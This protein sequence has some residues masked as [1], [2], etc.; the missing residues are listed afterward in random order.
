MATPSCRRRMAWWNSRTCP[1]SSSS[2]SAA[3]IN[4]GDGG[5]AL[6]G[7]AAL[8]AEAAAEE[9][10]AHATIAGPA[11]LPP[12]ESRITDTRRMGVEC[13]DDDAGGC[14]CCCCCCCCGRFATLALRDEPL[15]PPARGGVR[16]CSSPRRTASSCPWTLAAADADE[17][18]W[19][20]PCPC[21]VFFMLLSEG[22]IRRGLS[23]LFRITSTTAQTLTRWSSSLPATEAAKEAAPSLDVDGKGGPPS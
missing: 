19:Y 18:W 14:C 20:R 4:G 12:S 13:V 5:R 6:G 9:A 22:L 7:V 2:P 1:S 11:A 21:C 16:S 15:R 3:A 8:A 17:W 23:R 10:A